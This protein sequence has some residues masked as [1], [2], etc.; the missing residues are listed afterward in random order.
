MNHK[1]A[2]KSILVGFEESQAITQELRFRGYNALSCDLQDCSGPMPEYHLKMD[3]FQ[4]INLRKWDIIILH[5]PCTYTA[6]CGNRWYWNSSFRL[7]G[8]ALCK[9]SWDEACKVCEHV[10][11]EQPKTIMQKYIG[12]RSQTIHPWQ[13][14]HGETKETWLWLKGLPLLKP[15]NIVVGREHK[16]WRM[17]PTKDPKDRQKLRSKTYPGI[18]VAIAEQWT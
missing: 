7:E 14:G 6:I 12:K 13:F 2:Y 11:L 1:Q 17:P 3:I 15:T 8:I 5:P 9:K 16:I 4:A 10:A 18:A